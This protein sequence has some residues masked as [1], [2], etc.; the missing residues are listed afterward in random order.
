MLLG[1]TDESRKNIQFREI[2]LSDE[3]GY[4]VFEFWT[5]KFMGRFKNGFDIFIHEPE[6]SVFKDFH[7]DGAVLVENNL[8]GNIRVITIQADR[9][10]AV[11]W[12]VEYK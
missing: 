5:R 4:L 9:E 3:K 11:E 2:G 1:R 6:G 12:R 10:M 7:C 8:D